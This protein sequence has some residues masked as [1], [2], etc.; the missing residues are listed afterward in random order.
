VLQ[1]RAF[2]AFASLYM[3]MLIKQPLF[4]Y[5]FPLQS[6]AVEQA[7]EL[8]QSAKRETQSARRER[9]AFTF[10]ALHG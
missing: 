10:H 4:S 7:V 8:V 1:W 5:Y 9:Q 3:G 2:L 6:W